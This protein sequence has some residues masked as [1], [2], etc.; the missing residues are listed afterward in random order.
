MLLSY[1]VAFEANF[2][3]VKGGKL[4]GLR[5]GLATSGCS[6][7]S[8]SNGGSCF[9][10]RV[11]WRQ[12]GAGEGTHVISVDRC[13]GLRDTQSTHTYLHQT[14]SARVAISSAILIL[15]LVYLEEVLHLQPDNGTA[16]LCSFN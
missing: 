8:K 9:S 2:D 7:G 16:S 14:I 13:F 10:S 5:G 11:M 1:E 12:N 4:P 15:G 6:G 3:W